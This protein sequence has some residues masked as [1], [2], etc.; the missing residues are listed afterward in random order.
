MDDNEYI[1]VEANDSTNAGG[2]ASGYSGEC[3]DVCSGSPYNHGTKVWC[4]VVGNGS[5]QHSV[6]RT[7]LGCGATGFNQD[8]EKDVCCNGATGCAAICPSGGC[9]G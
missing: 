5:G 8:L 9:N 4:H 1:N 7:A 6:G 2:D 3:N